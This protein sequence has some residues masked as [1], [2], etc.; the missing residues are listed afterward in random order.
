MHVPH[1]EPADC[2]PHVQLDPLHVLLDE[3]LVEQK[4]YLV[5]LD[6]VDMTLVGHL[7]QLDTDLVSFHH[8]WAVLFQTRNFELEEP[9]AGKLFHVAHTSHVVVSD[10]SLQLLFFSMQEKGPALLVVFP[11][12]GGFK[13]L[14]T[15]CDLILLLLA[16]SLLEVCLGVV[17]CNSVLVGVG[18]GNLLH[19]LV[20][21]LGEGGSH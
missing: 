2:E 11:G 6:L 10:V 4:L 15:S 19:L 3:L 5:F 8:T 17:I 7:A 1:W 9:L 18:L 14:A 13:E 12:E 16:L 20:G 21:S